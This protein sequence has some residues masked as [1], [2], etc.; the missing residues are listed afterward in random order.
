M[1]KRELAVGEPKGFAHH[2]DGS[3]S[4]HFVGG[5]YGGMKFRS[6]PPYPPIEFPA[7]GR[8]PACVYHLSPPQG[9]YRTWI[10]LF[11]TNDN[12]TTMRRN[13]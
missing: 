9:R 12:V 8:R 4:F 10:Y 11:D 2:A 7:S 5:P 13:P 1:A 3:Q 6:Y